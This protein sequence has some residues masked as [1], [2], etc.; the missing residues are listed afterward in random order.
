MRD[1]FVPFLFFM[2][3][4]LVLCRLLLTF[5][6]PTTNFLYEEETTFTIGPDVGTDGN[7]PEI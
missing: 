2:D 5:A 7:G 1:V 3:N 6:E 4:Y